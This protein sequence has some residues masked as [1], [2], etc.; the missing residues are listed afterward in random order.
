MGHAVPVVARRVEEVAHLPA[1]LAVELECL[2]GGAP[3]VAEVPRLERGKHHKDMPQSWPLFPCV[4]HFAHDY[5]LHI[6]SRAC[7][8]TGT[9]STSI[10]NGS[11]LPSHVERPVHHMAA[12]PGPERIDPAQRELLGLLDLD[13]AS[14]RPTQLYS[15]A[16]GKR[17]ASRLQCSSRACTIPSH[18]LEVPSIWAAL[19]L[20][21]AVLE[22]RDAGSSLCNACAC[23]RG[24][25]PPIGPRQRPSRSEGNT[26]HKALQPS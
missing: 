9:H 4:C 7:T 21:R 6:S 1:E 12:T 2:T 11:G 19:H 17:C 22:W 14:S 18:H 23:W 3:A 13:A 26:I 15:C 24:G 8:R 5:R 10:Q 20:L 16:S 25:A